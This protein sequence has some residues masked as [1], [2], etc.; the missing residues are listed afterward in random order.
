MSKKKKKIIIIIIIKLEPI[1][2]VRGL[3]PLYHLLPHFRDK[4]F[5]SP[6]PLSPPNMGKSHG[7]RKLNVSR[8]LEPQA[9]RSNVKE[10]FNTNK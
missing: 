2:W 4:N 7:L 9:F 3:C 8:S 6:I 1:F 10:P 5:P